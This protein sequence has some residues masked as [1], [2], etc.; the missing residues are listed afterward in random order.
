MDIK[1]TNGNA[2][3][4]DD[5]LKSY[6]GGVPQDTSLESSFDAF[7]VDNQPNQTR[8]NEHL[9]F[10]QRNGDWLATELEANQP[11]NTFPIVVLFV[12]VLRLPV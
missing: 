6:S 10:Q 9:S 4:P 11:G 2:P 12:I 8:N 7:I 5:Y 1:K 3:T